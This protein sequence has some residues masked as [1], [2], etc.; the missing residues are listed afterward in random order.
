MIINDTL[1][2]D[3]KLKCIKAWD[4][5]YEKE[6]EKE[7]KNKRAVNDVLNIVIVRAIKQ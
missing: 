1:N 5:E 3:R 2:E 7:N 4:V 6:K